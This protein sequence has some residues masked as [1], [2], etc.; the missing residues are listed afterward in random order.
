[1]PNWFLILTADFWTMEGNWAK[2][3]DISL[4]W[5]G[6]LHFGMKTW[7]VH[8]YSLFLICNQGCS[9]LKAWTNSSK[10]DET[11]AEFSTLEVAICRL[12]NFGVI[13]KTAWLK[14][15]NS[16]QTTC[17]FSSVSYHA[18]CSR[19]RAFVRVSMEENQL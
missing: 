19:E 15:E 9:L 6:K 16:A 3:L 18:P 5:L 12:R 13:S 7:C 14:V 10:Q 2:A 8:S 1:M 11:R 17:R 4:S